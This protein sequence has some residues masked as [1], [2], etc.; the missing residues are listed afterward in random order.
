M[1]ECPSKGFEEV[2][3]GQKFYVPCST[4]EAVDVAALLMGCYRYSIWKTTSI[5]ERFWMDLGRILSTIL[6]TIA[7]LSY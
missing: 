6:H 3:I 2:W 1:L 5:R 4:Y 7:A